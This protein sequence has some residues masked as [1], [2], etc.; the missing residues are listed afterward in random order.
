MADAHTA[1]QHCHVYLSK[2]CAVHE[3]KNQ[4][5]ERTNTYTGLS[6]IFVFPQA[7]PGEG[8]LQLEFL[9]DGEATYHAWGV[10]PLQE[11]AWAR[12]LILDFRNFV[13]EQLPKPC[14]QPTDGDHSTWAGFYNERAKVESFATQ[15]REGWER[16]GWQGGCFGFEARGASSSLPSAV[17]PKEHVIN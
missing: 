6:R 9:P 7:C 11:S 16:G 12:E 10:D 13:H 8:D 14:L 4:A 2:V 17:C 3:Y 15:L 1:A 5:G